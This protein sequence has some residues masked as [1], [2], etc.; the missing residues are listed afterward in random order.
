MLPKFGTRPGDLVLGKTGPFSFFPRYTLP[1]RIRDGHMYVIGLS[2][3]GKSKLLEHCLYQDIQSGMGCGC[4]DPHSLLIEDLLRYLVTTKL[5]QSKHVHENLLYIDPTAK[6]IIP[7]NVLAA[8]GSPYE[9]AAGIKEAF[10]RTWPDSLKEAPHFSNVIM[11]SLIT[12]IS[13]NLTLIQLPTL[14]TNQDFREQC[15]SKV[16][17][18]SVIEFFHD[19]YDQWGKDAPFLR[20]STLNKVAA[21]SMNP[22]L[23]TMLGQKE[24][25]LNFR[26][27]LD[28]KKILLLDLGHCDVETSRL[29]ASLVLTGFEQAMRRRQKNNLYSLVLEEFG[30]YCANE[31]SEKTLAHVFSEARKFKLGM[32]VA[33]QDLS[34]LTP[35]MI[36]ALSNV[37]TKVIFGI[38]RAD[39]EFFAKNIG[40]VDIEVV[41]RDALTETQQPYFSPLPEQWESWCDRLRFQKPRQATVSTHDGKVAGIWT[42][43]IPPYQATEA[44][45]QAVKHASL[46]RYG[47][48]LEEAQ[49]NV[50][51]TLSQVEANPTG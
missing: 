48:P 49:R 17:D 44:Q 4:I 29:I 33:H 15:L 31:G 9:I 23:K 37:R 20:E 2:G 22:Y 51:E 36:G 6:Y 50:Q 38:G 24:N 28:E 40:R 7:F 46:A 26:Q 1:G 25:R 45:L 16:S 21:F 35:R 14:L 13:N 19:R 8:E 39:S 42:L 11:A 30:S 34:Q 32:T 43:S 12:L 27:I 5:H 3:K 41:K 47:I 10:C 18:H